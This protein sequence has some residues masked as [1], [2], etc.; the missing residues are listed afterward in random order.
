MTVPG[1]SSQDG[2]GLRIFCCREERASRGSG[3]IFLKR[4]RVIVSLKPP[5]HCDWEKVVMV[6]KEA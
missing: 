3:W 1:R 5:S 2:K 4:K 6:D